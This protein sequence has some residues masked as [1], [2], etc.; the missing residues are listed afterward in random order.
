MKA[1]II[2]LIVF[3]PWSLIFLG[4][5]VLYKRFTGKKEVKDEEA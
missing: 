1:L 5:V 2:S 4:I 3:V